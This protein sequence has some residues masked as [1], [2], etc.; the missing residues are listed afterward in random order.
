MIDAEHAEDAHLANSFIDE[1]EA[2]VDGGSPRDQ[3]SGDG[4]AP[5]DTAWRSALYP[6]DWP[7]QSGPPGEPFLHDFS[8]AGFEYGATLPEN[9]PDARII[10]VMAL[11]ADPT[12]MDDATMAFQRGIDELTM[13]GGGVLFV[14]EGHFRLNG[15]LQISGS[16]LILRGEGARR[17]RLQFTR[18][19][20][21]DYGAHITFSGRDETGPDISLRNDAPN[22][23]IRIEL[24]HVDGLAV[25]DDVLI[26][27]TITQAFVEAHGMTNVWGPFNDQWQP[28]FRR[29]I[30]AIEGG[31]EPAITVDVPLRYPAR[32]RDNASLRKE[33]SLLSGVAIEDLGLTNATEWE[34]AWGHNQVHVVAMSRVKDSWIRGVQSFSAPE[35]FRNRD[36]DGADLQSSGILI[37]DSK[38][39]TIA[40][41][42]LA[43]AQ[44]RGTGGNGY[45]FEIRRS[46]EILTRDSTGRNG[47]HNF[48]QNWGF[49]T[50]GCVWLRI[51]S[52]GGGAYQSI[53][54]GLAARGSSDFHHSLATANLIDS[55]Q[56][57]DGWSAVN[58]G[59]FS[60]GAGHS[61]TQNVFWNVGGSGLL[62]SFQFGLGY[63]IG[64]GPELEVITELPDI[65]GLGTEPEDWVEGLG[66]A[67][68]LSPSSLYEDQRMRR[69]N[70]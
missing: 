57:D 16:N 28:F 52:S 70:P 34:V 62:A 20:G 1:I 15:Q 45:L 50:N 51:H 3:G 56:F 66:E 30:I 55:S 6:T 4:S 41:T 36:A 46:N 42:H 5:V 11:G 17:T 32:L 26:G 23:S 27:W 53:E 10:D 13:A 8:Y 24:A 7:G 58:R 12:G 40:D 54:R 2:S 33:P 43:N 61:A 47:R 68:R 60:S 44:N 63:V 59:G 18:S 22:Q 67:P 64:T 35:G 48:I 9:D 65:A 49:G 69:V 14:P 37:E 39:V 31:E 25:G 29:T 38:R 21:L 19:E